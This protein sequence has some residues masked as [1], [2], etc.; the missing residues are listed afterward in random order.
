MRGPMADVDRQCDD[1]D[2]VCLRVR[3]T[4]R[5]RWLRRSL[6]HGDQLVAAVAVL[7]RELD[8]LSAALRVP[9]THD[10]TVV[11]AAIWLRGCRPPRRTR[12]RGPSLNEGRVTES[13]QSPG[14]TAS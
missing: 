4:L 9:A 6:D 12:A 2:Q 13:E 1:A 3:L 10:A 14:P 5:P 8:E 7:P 11:M